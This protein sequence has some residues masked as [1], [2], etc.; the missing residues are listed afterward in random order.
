MLENTYKI[1]PAFNKDLVLAYQPPPIIDASHL[2]TLSKHWLD[3]L[4]KIICTAD[5]RLM[6]N[7]INKHLGYA[8]NYPAKNLLKEQIQLIFHRLQGNLDSK[9]GSLSPDNRQALLCKLTEEIN[10]CS[11]GFHNRVNI[12]VDSF[13]QPR[14]LDELLYMVRKR[15]VENVAAQLSQEVH[16][17][18]HAWNRVSVIAAADGLGIKANLAEDIHHGSLSESKIRRALQQM[19]ARYFTPFFL[20][21]LLINAFIELIPEL[22]VE[23]QS[24]NG[25]CLQ[26]QEKITSLIKQCLPQFINENPKNTKDPNSWKNYFEKKT[27]KKDPFIFRFND[28]NYEKLYHS[29]YY[30]LLNNNYF[31]TPKINTLLENAYYNLF[32]NNTDT[33]YSPE[34]IICKLF[35][36]HQYYS[37]LAQLV[38]LRKK[39]P[40]FYETHINNPINL[41]MNEIFVRNC[42]DFNDFLKNQLIISE[43]YSEEIAQGFQLILNL[44]LTRKE[45]IIG[46]LANSL[47]ET[48]KANFNLLMLGALNNLELVKTIFAFVK[49]NEAF[50]SPQIA[51]KMLLMK[52]SD[53]CNA[54]MIAANKQRDAIITILGFLKNY[55]GR[56]ASDTLYK[57]FSQQ[58]KEDSYTALT[59]AA[60]DNPDL[61]NSILRFFTE[62][63]KIDSETFRKLLFPENSNGACTAL[64]LAIKN[65]ADSSLLI[66]NFISK[67]IKSFDYG[68]LQK[69]FL[70]KDENGFTIL[71]LAAQYHAEGL[72]ALLG[73]LERKLFTVDFLSALFL[74]IN[75]QKYNF[76]MLATKH[77][78]ETI[79]T[80]LEFIKK[81]RLFNSNLAR[82]LSDKNN[83][84]D[85]ALM[86]S[87]YH[88]T[89]MMSIIEFINNINKRN[90]SVI[91]Q[92][93]A[94]IFLIK[95]KAGLN[96]LML[97]A[98][99][100]PQSLQLIFEFIEKNPDQF[101]KENLS[102]LFQDKNR[103]GYNCLMLA[104]HNHYASTEAILNFILKNPIIFSPTFIDQY[105]TAVNSE[106]NNALMIAATYQPQI[107]KL[108]LD[109]LTN[110]VAPIG[111]IRIDTLK[112][113]VFEKVHDKEAACAVFFGGRYNYYKSVLLVTSQLNDSTAVNALLKFIDH[114]IQSL[115]IEVFIDLLTEK[116]Y[117]NNYIFF[118]ACSYYPDTLK[119]IL[120]FIANSAT[121][122]KLIP[123]QHF[124]TK[125]IFDQLDR[126][127]IETDEDKKLFDKVIEKCSAF[128]LIHF[129]KDLFAETSQ[130]LKLITDKLFACYL[131]E[132]KDRKANN[133]T[134]TTNFSFF[135][136]R[137]S[138]TQKLEAALALQK[139]LD[140][141]D[142]NKAQA[143]TK[144][145]HQFPGVIRWR[146]GNLFA[147]YQK[148]AELELE[149]EYD[150]YDAFELDLVNATFPGV[151]T[152]YFI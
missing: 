101:T 98:K 145:K 80:I 87:R 31:T 142:V 59:L 105:I 79:A 47:L 41:K 51:E 90:N 3:D 45:Y 107:V 35:N 50:I 42:L 126:W 131:N 4:Q 81:R 54:L 39:Y 36:E 148:I 2:P 7:C 134:Y 66:L 99:D 1:D 77:Q 89:A 25:L 84:G 85:N 93:L 46:E 57:L 151:K 141:Y 69:M 64:M 43:E 147:V 135:K 8:S 149:L 27:N 127:K 72:S 103:F 83:Q 75:S 113:V 76:L 123:V 120:K 74:E 61:L 122:E 114:H 137:Y 88:P 71:M 14:N 112:K 119:N 82:L 94:D 146:L 65:Q 21:N 86:L 138:T 92:S 70:E 132:L 58:Q 24:E 15:L 118:P 20:P 129:N 13:Q 128:L 22:E 16:G 97:L 111:P 56:F 5:P 63:I 38:E 9:L 152:S 53:H 55:I 23:K 110:N 11:A 95:N 117:K 91:A 18:I 78:P 140:S 68:V 106:K 104:A 67:N 17:E 109:F 125:F 19:F 116:D 139:V 108:L 26:T 121:H 115:G 100:E 124:S 33:F 150:T 49:K 96:L 52:N 60:R 143:L 136:W 32:L 30:A 62:N 6:P 144:L 40:I 37:L 133:I 73:L 29:F 130:N 48:N 28:I 44:K 10:N 102:N 34:S 12:I